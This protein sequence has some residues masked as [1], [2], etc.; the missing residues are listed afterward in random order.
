MEQKQEHDFFEEEKKE[1]KVE[2]KKLDA[3][4]EKLVKVSAFIIVGCVLSLLVALTLKVI[5]WLF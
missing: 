2:Q 5:L 4:S 3:S 1:E